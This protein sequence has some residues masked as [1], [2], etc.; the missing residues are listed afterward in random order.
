MDHD[1]AAVTDARDVE[2]KPAFSDA[3]RQCRHVLPSTVVTSS[4]TAGWTSVLVELHQGQASQE[5]FETRPTPDQTIVV[6]TRGKQEL[7]SFTGGSWRRAVYHVGTIGMTPGGEV[8]RLRRRMTLAAPFE[9]A[10]LYIPQRFF[11]ETAD[12]YRRAGHHPGPERLTALAMDDPLIGQTAAALVRAMRAGAADL[13]AETAMSWLA[14]HLLSAHA[15]WEDLR[16]DRRSPGAISD[17]RLSRVLEYMKAHLS[18]PLTLERLAA[19]AYVSKYH[20]VRLFRARTGATPH[21]FLVELRMDAA[22]HMLASTDLSV[23]AISARCGYGRPAHFGTAFTKRF[24]MP[25]TAY[26]RHAHGEPA[27]ISAEADE[28][29]MPAGSRPAGYSQPACLLHQDPHWRRGIPDRR[30][31]AR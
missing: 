21:A 26:R 7:E 22:R 8:D 29:A 12:Y 28:I 31:A 30:H 15:S 5:P 3:S 1:G 18:A 19:E 14:A 9:K 2:H 4:E 27:S 6:M 17:P 23:S 11:I 20:F 13:Y 10:N 24:G 25:P 16:D